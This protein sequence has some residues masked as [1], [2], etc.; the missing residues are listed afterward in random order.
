MGMA[1]CYIRTDDI[2]TKQIQNGV[3]IDIS[4]RQLT[5]DRILS[6]LFI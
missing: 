1:G 6:A 5:K 4:G 2:L 3:E